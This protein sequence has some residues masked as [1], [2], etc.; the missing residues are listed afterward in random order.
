MKC[1]KCGV[2]LSVIKDDFSSLIKDYALNKQLHV[3]DTSKIEAHKKQE[4]EAIQSM[5]KDLKIKQSALMKSKDIN[6]DVLNIPLD[7]PSKMQLPLI[8]CRCPY[9]DGTCHNCGKTQSQPK[10]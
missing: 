9:F 3:C 7:A 1:L 5:V 10:Q 6:L 2:E 4:S 8:R